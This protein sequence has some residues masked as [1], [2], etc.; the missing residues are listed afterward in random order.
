M[1]IQ[2]SKATSGSVT[3]HL[4]LGDLTNIEVINHMCQTGVFANVLETYVVTQDFLQMSKAQK[5]IL[6][7][8]IVERSYKAI[9]A[10][11]RGTSG[12]LQIYF[13]MFIKLLECIVLIILVKTIHATILRN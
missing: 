5:V 7:A 13:N 3:M 6:Q 4:I 11:L 2:L 9:M 1:D 10:Y 8:N 12:F